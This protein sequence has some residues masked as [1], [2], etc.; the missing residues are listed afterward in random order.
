M[1]K[2]VLGLL[3]CVLMLGQGVCQ[4]QLRIR[5]ICRVKGQ[6]EN[7]L[8]GLGLVVG[9]NGTGDAD[10]PTTRAL[11]QMMSL[12]GTPLGSDPNGRALLAELKNAQNVAS[13]YVTVTVPG[14]GARQ[15]GQLNCTVNALSAKSLEGGYLVPTALL[16]PR[17][18]DRRVYALAQGPIVT[19]PGA[20]STSG[21]VHGGCRL[22][23]DIQT[24]F[25]KDGRVTLVLD[26]NH[27]GFHTAFDIEEA[28]NSPEAFGTLAGAGP[29]AGGN[30]YAGAAIAKALDQVNIEI[31]IPPAY[32]RNEVQFVYEVLETRIFTPR[33]DARVV[34][35]QR[36]GVI[37]IGQQVEVGPVAVTHKNLS[38]QAGSG[39]APG[40]FVMM[41]AT[42]STSTTKLQALVDALNALKVNS[43]DIIDIIKGLQRSGDLYGHVIIE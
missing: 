41:D 32:A 25:V 15:G 28:L 24:P 13:V 20:T 16:G 3:A 14:E 34:I 27:A 37:V 40:P 19:V 7:T 23:T 29:N 11:A 17:P 1:K 42:A 12:L 35:D 21:K 30:R 38:I 36:N 33:N 4:A 10:A 26:K 8:H 39:P 43:S 5:D 22:E 2:H 6:E 31:Q 9:L 18:G